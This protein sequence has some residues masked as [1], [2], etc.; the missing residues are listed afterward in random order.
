MKLRYDG[1]E[2]RHGEARRGRQQ[3]EVV[4]LQRQFFL[5]VHSETAR[6]LNHDT[7]AWVA[8]IRVAD[9]PASRPADALGE[10]SPGSE[11]TYDF[12]EWINHNS[13]LLQIEYGL[14]IVDSP[15]ASA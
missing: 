2:T 11:Q 12:G 5:S 14:S 7:E 3:Y 13:G 1:L 4:R 10:Y 9:A 8:K 15:E 6:P